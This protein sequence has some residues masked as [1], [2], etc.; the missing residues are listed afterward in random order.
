MNCLNI[1]SNL[2]I[3]K[4]VVMS[5]LNLTTTNI[6]KFVHKFEVARNPRFTFINRFHN[7]MIKNWLADGCLEFSVHR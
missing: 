6:H 4:A 2:L 1:I 3:N 7:Q 5:K